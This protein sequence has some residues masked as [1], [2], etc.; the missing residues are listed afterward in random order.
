MQRCSYRV[1]ADGGANALFDAFDRQAASSSRSVALQ[2][3]GSILGCHSRTFAAL[4][5]G[6]SFCRLALLATLTGSIQLIRTLSRSQ[7]PFSFNGRIA[8]FDRTCVRFTSAKAS[9]CSTSGNA[10]SPTPPI[11]PHSSHS[12][13]APP[14]SA[15][16]TTPTS[17]NAWPSLLLVPH[18][19][20]FMCARPWAAGLTT[21]CRPSAHARGMQRCR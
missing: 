2:F 4:P 18:H 6:C 3:F 16:K 11:A 5:S 19:H 8:A 7:H 14:L 12:L 20:A 1:C 10:P 13:T 21:C 15:T 17:T 9:I